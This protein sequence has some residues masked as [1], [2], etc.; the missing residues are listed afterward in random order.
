MVRAHY[1]NTISFGP[2][3]LAVAER[4]L[5][6]DGKPVQLGGRAF[7]ILVALVER[8]GQV[9]S[10]QELAERVWPGL[11]VD[12]GA[13][14]V[15]IASLRKALGGGKPGTWYVTTSQGRGYC[16]VAPTSPSN[17]D[18][19]AKDNSARRLKS[20]LPTRVTRVVGRESEVEELATRVATERFL[21]IVGAGGIGKTTVAIAVG[22]RLIGHFDG[23]AIFFDLASVRDSRLLLSAITSTLGLVQSDDPL[24]GLI[25]HLRGKPRLLILDNCE[26]LIEPVA[27]VAER[28]LS[29]APEAHILATS[30]E[31]I[32]A[33]GEHVWHLKPL[34][35]PPDELPLTV[36]Q[37]LGFP[38]AQLFVER[39]NGNGHC[40]DPT[41]RDA[42]AVARICQK[43]DGIALAIELAAGRANA[44]GLHEIAALISS[45][46]E[47][48]GQGRRTAAPRHQTLTAMLDWSY[49]LLPDIEKAVFGRLS[50][51]V[52]T[53][54]LE[55]AKAIAIDTDADEGEVVAAL[56]GLVA[57]SL[58]TVDHS[59]GDAPFRLLDITR[60]YAS[61]KLLESGESGKV[62]RRH[63]A[64]FLALLERAIDGPPA[65]GGKLFSSFAPHLANVRAAL[66]SSF[67][68]PNELDVAIGLA[69]A[70]GRLFLELSL[71]T[72]CSSWSERAIAALDE[73]SLG[74]RLEM[75]LQTAL[76]F[77]SIFTRGNDDSAGRA[78]KRALELA[79]RL[80]DS[81]YQG[82][83]LCRLFVYHERMGDFRAGLEYA[84]RVEAVAREIGDPEGIAEA[85]II[86]GTSCLH[87]G[88]LAK[89]R[90]KYEA[91]MGK[92]P[93]APRTDTYHFGSLNF[94]LGARNSA[95][96]VLWLQGFPDQAVAT[97]RETS[98]K[99]CAFNHLVSDCIA[100]VWGMRVFL[101]NRNLDDVER[102]VASLLEHAERHSLMPYHTLARGMAGEI[103][104]RRG[105]PEAGI[106]QLRNALERLHGLRYELQ[107]TS[108]MIAIADGM[109][110]A[111]RPLEAD[112]AIDEAIAVGE[113]NG[114]LF[115]MPE[116][117]RIKATILMSLDGSLFAEAEKYLH[118]SRDLAREQGALAWELRTATA[119]ASLRVRQGR[120]EQARAALLPVYQRFTEGFDGADMTE[121]RSLLDELARP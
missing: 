57:K 105:Q 39:A 68:D 43:L 67:D 32:R 20:Q 15:Q 97:A 79:A 82:A 107:T 12:E 52:G 41:D 11:S 46:I 83:L 91:A 25:A 23:N 49:Q 99:A 89:A 77:S 74:T 38:A 17:A 100:L 45:K 119:L 93:V 56:A 22:H 30:R 64:Y 102:C 47:L 71:L 78:L 33:D 118:R 40:F 37:I 109:A 13:L 116:A 59:N 8:A 62:S 70:S 29:G 3:E 113:R 7:D 4:V 85:Q 81:R 94:H 88:Y 92:L 42:R 84:G 26:H 21:T 90:A 27:A 117:L 80:R 53:F 63:A 6:E 72:E 10:K 96:R 44:F 50:I 95:A 9:V 76:G 51:F 14:R 18:I 58:V 114:D 108:L 48:S 35:C 101:W 75:Q 19:R 121:A 65:P 112:K 1:P 103:L 2:F 111:G 60:N 104:I 106:A 110:L 98:E 87:A 86:F 16:F 34:E 69:V 55:A 24:P 120:P 5:L 54:T 36:E 66:E 115:M 31:A 73:N 61:E 28:I